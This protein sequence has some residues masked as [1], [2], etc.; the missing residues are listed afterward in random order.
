MLCIISNDILANADSDGASHPDEPSFGEGLMIWLMEMLNYIP[1]TG[2]S[3]DS[4]DVLRSV[5]T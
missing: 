5:V 2:T 3:A 1:A 4:A